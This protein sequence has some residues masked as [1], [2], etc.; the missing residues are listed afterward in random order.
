MKKLLVLILVVALCSFSGIA[1]YADGNKVG[2]TDWSFTR[3]SCEYT[4]D[5]IVLSQTETGIPDNH[6]ISILNIPFEGTDSIEIT[7]RVTMDD[8]VASGRN[9]NDVWMGIGIMG[10]PKFINW[11]NSES[12]GWA[13]DTPGL[14]TRFFSYDGDLRLESSIYQEGYK[15]AGDDESSQTVDTW[16]LLSAAAGVSVTKDVTLKLSYDTDAADAT[17]QFYN[18]YVNGTKISTSGELCH[19]DRTVAFP[20]GKMY[21][22]IVMNTQTKETNSLSKVVVKNINGVDYTVLEKE[23]TSTSVSE[24][25]GCGGVTCLGSSVAALCVLAVSAIKRKHF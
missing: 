13:K 19:I 16:Q 15:T 8:Y 3:T 11:R 2:K 12:A 4:G 18:L 23:S 21:L 25:K 14:F 17:K 20:E 10:V 9:A 5:G 1:A 7:F 24:K 6:A 22:T